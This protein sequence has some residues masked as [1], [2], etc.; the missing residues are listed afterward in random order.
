MTSCVGRNERERDNEARL[1]GAGQVEADEAPHV[2][3]LRGQEESKGAGDGREHKERADEG[4]TVLREPVVQKS[5]SSDPNDDEGTLRD[6]EKR[7]LEG[8][9]S[10]SLDDEGTEVAQSTVGNVGDE[11]EEGEQVAEGVS[12]EEPRYRLSG[13]VPQTPISA[14]RSSPQ[15]PHSRLVVGERLPDLV[16]TDLALLNT[17]LVLGH[18][19]NH[20]EFLLMSESAES[21]WRVGKNIAENKCPGGTECA[22][23]EEFVP[24]GRP[25]ACTITGDGEGHSPSLP[26]SP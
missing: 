13:A 9:E 2:S 22:D 20:D 5:A 23:N 21:G 4:T 19:S 18:A 11:S 7:G 1:I 25:S 26:W 12:M 6:T 24:L 8:V 14:T 17:R 10:E 16:P 3:V 15:V